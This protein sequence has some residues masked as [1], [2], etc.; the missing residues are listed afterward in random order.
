MTVGSLEFKQ[1]AGA[2]IAWWKTVLPQLPQLQIRQT[3]TDLCAFSF[4]IQFMTHGDGVMADPLRGA[5]NAVWCQV[6]T[7]I[8]GHPVVVRVARIER[9]ARC[10][11]HW[12]HLPNIQSYGQPLATVIWRRL[13]RVHGENPNSRLTCVLESLHLKQDVNPFSGS[14]AFDAAQQSKANYDVSSRWFWCMNLTCTFCT[15]ITKMNF[16]GRGFRN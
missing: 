10:S 8:G 5:T 11:E 16:Q 15:C 9:I 4:V 7:H 2:N 12:R 3:Y 13:H 1:E 6:I 14:Q